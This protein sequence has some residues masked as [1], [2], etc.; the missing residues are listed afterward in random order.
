MISL[1]EKWWNWSKIIYIQK[2]KYRFSFRYG[3]Y[4]IYT[5]VCFIHTQS[6]EGGRKRKEEREE[7]SIWEG[8]EKGQ[9]A[10]EVA[11]KSNGDLLR[12]K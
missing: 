8:E 12:S 9:E 6:G 7:L 5:R 4:V 1:A 3:S 10:G 2:D 11:G